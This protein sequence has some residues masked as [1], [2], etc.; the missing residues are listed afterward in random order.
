[1][2]RELLV[3]GANVDLQDKVGA[4]SRGVVLCFLA[5]E[6]TEHISSCITHILPMSCSTLCFL[7]CANS[8][9]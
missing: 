5:L 7:S 2:V 9:T 8:C 3:Q 1:M 6:I 4:C